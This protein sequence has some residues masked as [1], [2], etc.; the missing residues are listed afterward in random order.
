MNKIALQLSVLAIFFLAACSKKET[1]EKE[2]KYLVAQPLVID[3]SFTKEYVADIHAMHDVEIRARVKGFIENIYVDEGKPVKAGQILFSISNNHYKEELGKSKALLNS[4]IAEAKG[5]EL[6]V[7][8]IQTLVAKKI[9]SNTELQIAEIKLESAKAKIEEAKANEAT[10]LLNLSLT[11]IRAPFDG[12]INRIPNKIGSLIDEGTLLTDFSNNREVLAYF[13]V[14]ESE[15]L[16]ITTGGISSNK[17]D[18]ELLM[19]NNQLFP[20]KG[21]IETV[22]SEIDKS[23]GN[24]AFRARFYN[25][26]DLLKH[27]SSGKVLIKNEL[28]KA[29]LIPQKSTFEIQENIYVFVVDTNNTVQMRRVFPKLRIQNLY[30]LE[31]GLKAD[32]KIVLEGIQLVKQGDKISTTLISSREAISNIN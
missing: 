31:S 26:N 23:T 17:N 29:M 6:E 22:E 19:A 8:N 15:Y 12:V 24:I 20:G 30:V 9:V 3:T 1:K 14:S 25:Q 2:E 13:H 18:I 11:K 5:A 10:A 4:A 27:G 21:R 7:K 32:E 16:N 28:K